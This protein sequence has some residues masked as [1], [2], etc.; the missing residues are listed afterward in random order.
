MSVS[1]YLTG[2]ASNLVLSGQETQSIEASVETIASRLDNHFGTD[3]SKHFRFG[4]SKRDTILPRIADEHS[5]VDYMVVF[6]TGDGK[7]K[8]Q[9][10]LDR[11]R[12]FAEA[13]YG[14]S[15]IYQSHPTI[16]LS[17]NHINF[18]LVPA[19]YEF[20]LQIPSPTAS[21]LEWLPTDPARAEK[22]ILD[23]NRSEQYQ[24]K[25]LVRLAKYWNA[26]NGYPFSSFLLEQQIVRNYFFSCPGLKDYFYAFW[27]NL[28][29]RYETPQWV[30]DKIDLAKERAR[31]AK[32]FEDKDMP[33][34]AEAE[35]KKIVP[36]L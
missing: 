29:Y 23:K 1:T 3:V 25:P 30:K 15:E 24:I 34:S 14:R 8:P 20:G 6:S 17:L 27:S 26:R 4:S 18:E 22:D 9:T 2:L 16:V 32:V 7:K 21:Y 33:A 11:L 28:L 35:I 36:P 5:D 19:I 10:Y 31:A 13:K 12:Q